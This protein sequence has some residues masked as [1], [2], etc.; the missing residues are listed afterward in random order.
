MALCPK[1][2]VAIAGMNPTTHRPIEIELEPLAT[3]GVLPS[4]ALHVLRLRY[5][6][7]GHMQVFLGT[8]VPPGLAQFLQGGN[9]SS[10][11]LETLEHGSSEQRCLPGWPDYAVL[12]LETKDGK[13]IVCMPPAL[14]RLRLRRLWGGGAA[15]ALGAALLASPYSVVGAG[16]LVF[17]SHAIRGGLRV[18]KAIYQGTM[19]TG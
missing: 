10:L 19:V 2:A 3:S 16:L 7:Q 12:G 15:A 1:A 4:H 5:R 6:P 17:A 18:S 13:R 11:H 14:M 8:H 9:V